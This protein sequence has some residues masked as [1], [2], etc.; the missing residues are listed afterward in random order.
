MALENIRRVVTGHNAEGKSVVL[1]DEHP[2]TFAQRESA[3]GALIWT[4]DGG[5]PV[6]N[7]EADAANRELKIGYADGTIFRVVSNGPG[8]AA[9]MH[10]TDSIDYMIVLSGEMDMELDDGV[11]VH[12]TPGTLLVQRGTAHRWINQGTEPCVLVFIMI[13]SKP[14]E[15]DG[16]PLPPIAH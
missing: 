7:N 8:V 10:R 2:K 12:L 16:K 9:N 5:F 4:T 11:V 14:I 3:V 13:G 15:I 1:I 6:D